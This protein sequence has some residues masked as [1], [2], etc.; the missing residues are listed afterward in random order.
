M[1]FWTWLVGTRKPEPVRVATRAPFPNASSFAVDARMGED[2]VFSLPGWRYS[3]PH[4]SGLADAGAVLPAPVAV[5]FYGSSVRHGAPGNDVDVL[6]LVPG[7]DEQVKFH[8]CN[9][10]YTYDDYGACTKRGKIFHIAV[11]TEGEFLRRH[12]SGAEWAVTLARDSVLLAGASEVGGVR[13]NQTFERFKCG[14]FP[15][16]RLCLLSPENMQW[17]MSEELDRV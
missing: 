5:V 11:M 14:S 15:G 13:W 6:W 8:D 9:S 16:L 3:Y 10:L 4:I 17:A 2:Y 7:D 12:A 1:S